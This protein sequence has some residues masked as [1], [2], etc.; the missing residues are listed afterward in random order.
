MPPAN[1][2][3]FQTSYCETRWYVENGTTFVIQLEKIDK[4]KTWTRLYVPEHYLRLA[5]EGDLYE[6]IN[7][8][9]N[10]DSKGEFEE[11]FGWWVK[12]ADGNKSSQAQLRVAILY[13]E[14]KGVEAS[15]ELYQRYMIKSALNQRPQPVAL[16]Q[17]GDWIRKGDIVGQ[18]NKDV[19]KE[20]THRM[21]W[22]TAIRLFPRDKMSLSCANLL[23]N[24]YLQEGDIEKARQ[25][26]A[27]LGI[28]I[29][30]PEQSQDKPQ[31]ATKQP[32][33]KG[34]PK[35][36]SA[37]RITRG[38]PSSENAPSPSNRATKKALKRW[39]GAATASVAIM[40]ISLLYCNWFRGV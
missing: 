17:V 37:Q 22:H 18:D 7:L 29:P 14:G 6:R 36:A 30:D 4:S 11:A 13:K 2:E 25:Y 12:A 38:P 9:L 39:T 34:V 23:M 10:L 28:K 16:L 32:K 31:S 33:Q 21:L 26:A 24:E 3:Q 19:L 5:T 40:S 20:I 15:E 27:C 8:A 35:Q 1:L